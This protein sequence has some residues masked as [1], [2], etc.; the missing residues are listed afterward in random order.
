M[1]GHAVRAVTAPDVV[2]RVLDVLPAT[3]VA[4]VHLHPSVADDP[5]VGSLAD[6]GLDVVADP[7]LDRADALVDCDGS[8]VDLR[9]GEAMARV[10]DVLTR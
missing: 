3:A 8:I 6:R 4:R 2:R 1:L 5:A 10:R 9:V 7:A